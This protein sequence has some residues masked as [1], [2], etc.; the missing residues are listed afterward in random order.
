MTSPDGSARPD[1]QRAA[2]A[3]ADFTV[4]RLEQTTMPK[5]PKFVRPLIMGSAV[6]RGAG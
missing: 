4:S 1:D 3:A 5:A 2:I 6:A